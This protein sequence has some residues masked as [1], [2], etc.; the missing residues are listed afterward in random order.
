[1]PNQKGNVAELQVEVRPSDPIFVLFTSGSTGKPKGM[2]L[3]HVAVCTHA[4]HNGPPQIRDETA[5][6]T[7]QRN[8]LPVII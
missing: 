6:D 4:H 8:T 1:M 5:T 7:T 2:I 3:E